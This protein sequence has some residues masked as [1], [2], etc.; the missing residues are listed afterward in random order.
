MSLTRYQRNLW[1]TGL[2]VGMLIILGAVIG[3]NLFQIWDYGNQQQRR[4]QRLNQEL[5]QARQDYQQANL[6]FQ[7]VFDSG[8][9]T[10]LLKERYGLV[11]PHDLKVKWKTPELEP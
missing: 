4:Y 2:N 10:S 9:T 1:F 11:D 3:R 8:Q 6:R 7:R 5:S